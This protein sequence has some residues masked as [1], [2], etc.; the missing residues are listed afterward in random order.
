MANHEA[1]WSMNIAVNDDDIIKQLTGGMQKVGDAYA[2]AL[3]KAIKSATSKSNR[4]NYSGLLSGLISEIRD[5]EGNLDAVTNAAHNFV[6][7]FEI[8]EK[9][10]TKSGVKNLFAGFSVDEINKVTNGFEEYIKKQEELNRLKNDSY[11]KGSFKGDYEANTIKS[12]QE[13]KK[14]YK[15]TTAEKKKYNE[16]INEHLKQMGIETSGIQKEITQYSSL[17]SIYE[18]IS[19]VQVSKGTEEA[20]HKQQN[21]LAVLKEIVEVESKNKALIGF[22][23]TQ[24]ENLPGIANSIETNQMQMVRGAINDYVSVLKKTL[25]EETNAFIVNAV[26][27]ASEISENLN[28]GNSSAS[29]PVK[30]I[31]EAL[32]KFNVTADEAK[33]KAIEFSKALEQSGGTSQINEGNVKNLEEY[34]AW[35]QRY[36]DLNPEGKIEDIIGNNRGLGRVFSGQAAGL[37]EYKEKVDEIKTSVHSLIEETSGTGG[38]GSGSGSENGIGGVSSETIELLSQRITTLETTVTELKTNFDNLGNTETFKNISSEVET[39]RQ[40]ISGLSEEVRDL[41]LTNNYNDGLF[42]SY[43]DSIANL[44]KRLDDAVTKFNE[45]QSKV[46]STTQAKTDISSEAKEELIEVRNEAEKTVEIINKVFRGV[47]SADA[48]GKLSN[49][50]KYKGATFFTDDL[51]IAKQYGDYIDVVSVK[52]ENAFKVNGKGN[53]WDNIQ[54]LGD[55]ID[56]ESKKALQLANELKHS[57]EEI[58]SELNIPIDNDP[59]NLKTVVSTYSIITNEIGKLMEVSKQ[60]DIEDK[61]EIDSRIHRLALLRD[62]YLEANKA[63]SDFS[64]DLT[65][66]YGTKTTDELSEYAKS[67][68]YDGAIFNNIIDAKHSPIVSGNEYIEASKVVVAFYEQQV[69]YFERLSRQGQEYIR[70]IYKTSNETPVSTVSPSQVFDN[71]IQQN[72]VMLENYKNTVAEIDRLKLEPETDETKRKLEELNK[73]ADYFASKI[74]VIRSENGHEVNRSMMQ[75]NGIWNDNLMSHYKSDQIKGFWDIAGE[76]SGLNV[77][78]VTNEFHSIAEEIQNIES[79]SEGLR[80]ALTKDLSESSAYVSKL[81]AAYIGIADANETLKVEAH[82]KGMVEAATK[83]LDHFLSKYPELEKFKNVFGYEKAHEFVKTD[84]WNNFLATL[85]KAHTYLESIGYDFDKVNKTPTL[86][87]DSNGQLSF[88]ENLATAEDKLEQ[89]VRETTDALQNQN[90]STIPGQINMEEYLASQARAEDQLEQQVRETTSAIADQQ[91]AQQ[92]NQSSAQ[93]EA[94]KSQLE[95]LREKVNE[96][97]TAFDNKTNAITNEKIAMEIAAKSEVESL[98]SVKDKV[99]EL[100]GDLSGLIEKPIEVKIQNVESVKDVVKDAVISEEIIDTHSLENA[101]KVSDSLKERLGGVLDV[102][103]QIRKDSEGK[104]YISYRLTGANGSAWVGENGTILREN[105]KVSNEL[106]ESKR[107]QAE[108]EKAYTQAL[109]DNAK[110][111]EQLEA[112][113]IQRVKEELQYQQER[114]RS[115]E[116]GRRQQQEYFDSLKTQSKQRETDSEKVKTQEINRLLSERLKAYEKIREFENQKSLTTGKSQLDFLDKQ[117]KEQQDIFLSTTKQLKQYGEIASIH[118]QESELADIR[119]NKEKE[120][121]AILARQNDS[122][123]NKYR[124]SIINTQKSDL[125]K[126]NNL[127]VNSNLS[128]QTDEY[129]AK[130]NDIKVLLDQIQSHH[131]D[132]ANEKELKDVEQLQGQVKTLYD[133]LGEVDRLANGAKASNIS[134]NISKYIHDNTRLSQA[135]KVALEELLN[136]LKQ[137]GLTRTELNQINEEFGRLKTRIN[138]AGEAGKSFGT[139]F[140]TKMVHSLASQLNYLISFYRVIGYIRSAINTVRELDTALVDLRKTTSMTNSELEEFYYDANNVAKQMGVTTKEIIEQASAW[141]RLN[142]IGLLYGNI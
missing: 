94:E 82:N 131:L 110:Y 69:Q 34:V 62:E 14:E 18:K 96:V 53:N 119:L 44:T 35:T 26:S 58:R 98:Q 30:E 19:N 57:Y 88:I 99:N 93:I 60:A 141:S 24:K 111:D 114:Q 47:D 86:F 129:K 81:K 74:T 5:A 103:K 133:E 71:E 135:N 33:Q 126:Y 118:K 8:L 63:Y 38:L 134:A 21:L 67:K 78:N 72:L 27:K 108:I 104:D 43:D 11:E 137:V 112:N 45:L 84:E 124:N 128:K 16:Q 122:N 54:I 37:G 113:R 3:E 49:S 1:I 10:Q 139:I 7:Q 85:P 20:I 70:E 56:E 90:A 76:K 107:R 87:Q 48:L 40:N 36:L 101:V 80:N 23:T 116:E 79:K 55:G 91:N 13:V 136:R 123:F 41:G 12:L 65:H 106:T 25:R 6:K 89:Q 125:N 102:M 138:Q 17:F 46:S 117:K 92:P 42:E 28:Q 100:K 31:D 22:R 130:L 132:I 83:D 115:L 97:T 140:S 77:H 9:A 59:L 29:Q 52:L 50:D 39:L 95:S 68:G 120:L 73:L 105:L 61:K 142:K 4:N 15:L 51:E 32:Q 2:D 64:K 75:F 127:N 121:E 66:K 109:K